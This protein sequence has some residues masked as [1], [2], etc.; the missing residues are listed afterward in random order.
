MKLM[1]HGLAGR[2]PS[3]GLIAMIGKDELQGIEEICLGFLKRFTF[4]EDVRKFLEGAGESAFR[5]GFIDCSQ[6]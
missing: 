2:F 1:P 6:L 5:G 4:G 3:P